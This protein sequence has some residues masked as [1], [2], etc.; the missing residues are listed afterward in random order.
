MST[1]PIFLV[2]GATGM[3][4]TAVADRLDRAGGLVVRTARRTQAGTV[5][6]D[7]TQ[8]PSSWQVPDHV[9]VA[10]LLAAV[11][12]LE[13]CRRSPTASRAVNVTGTIA[14]AKR[15]IERGAFVIFPSTNLVFDGSTA[16]RLA[17]DSTGPCTEYGRQKVE[18]EARLLELGDRVCVVRFTKV[19]S[20]KTVLI[21]RWV[22][23][24][25]AG[26]TVRPFD[27]FPLAPVSLSF[28]TTVLERVAFE[29][30]SGVLQVSATHDVSYAQV[31]LRLCGQLGVPVARV[32]AV[33]ARGNGFDG[34]HLPAFT[35]LDASRLEMIFDLAP[36]SPYEAVDACVGLTESEPPRHG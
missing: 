19:L 12:S 24:L 36:P 8:D 2:T 17:D 10:F 15:L 7:L 5:H 31:V 18:V 9:S 35:S 25:G 32:S 29:K 21:R 3:L 4:G 16:R 1:R 28:A 26:R 23:D 33:P 20:P 14:L 27:D 34:E 11:T 13:S 30:P 6:V 22:D